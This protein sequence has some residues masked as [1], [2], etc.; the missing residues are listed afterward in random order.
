[1]MDF[2]LTIDGE[3]ETSNNDIDIVFLNDDIR[4]QQ[5]F[6]RV[7]S[8]IDDWYDENTVGADL[9][10]IIG[11]VANNDNAL[12]GKNKII[13]ALTIDA[14]YKINEIYILTT[15]NK[16]NIAYKIYL[17]NSDKL[18]SKILYVSIDIVKGVNVRI[19][20]D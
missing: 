17:R 12:I 1:M 5:A 10:E 3:L 14:T 6:C 20:V 16:N 8:V 4:F 13:S 18:T 9:E 15:L 2:K 7:Q 19:G 11:F